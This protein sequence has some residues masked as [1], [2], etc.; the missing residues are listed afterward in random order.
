MTPTLISAGV[1]IF[2]TITSGWVTYLLTRKKYHSEVD[3]NLI[4]NMQESLEF[5]TKLSDDN[6]KRLQE[7]LAD[8]DKLRDQFEAVLTENNSLRIEVVKLRTQISSL[9][10]ELKKFNKENK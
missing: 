8:Y 7:I 10:K 5:Y 9:S 3:N 2:T 6:S 1:G 4:T